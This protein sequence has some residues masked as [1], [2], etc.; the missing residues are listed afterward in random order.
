[1][2]AQALEMSGGASQSQSRQSWLHNTQQ[3]V[4]CCSSHRMPSNLCTSA[5]S[6][7]AVRLLSKLNIYQALRALGLA[8]ELFLDVTVHYAD[9]FCDVCMQSALH[10]GRLETLTGIQFAAHLKLSLL[11][12]SIKPPECCSQL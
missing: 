12:S 4:S 5:A 9:V 3:I 7:L 8:D 2:L 10:R 6:V 11:M 1:M